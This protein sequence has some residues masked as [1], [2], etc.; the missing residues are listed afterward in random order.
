MTQE[1]QSRLK[2]LVAEKDSI[3]KEI[4]EITKELNNNGF[5]LQGNLVDKEGNL[6][7]FLN[8]LYLH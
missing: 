3:E 2:N 8:I 4:Q 7:V 6:Q 1:I 5:G